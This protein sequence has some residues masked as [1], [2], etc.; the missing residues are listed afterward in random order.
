MTWTRFFKG[1]IQIKNG[2]QTQSCPGWWLYPLPEDLCWIY[3]FQGHLHQ[4]L[5]PGL[6]SENLER[7]HSLCRPS[8]GFS[9]LVESYLLAARSCI[10]AE[11]WVLP[12]SCLF[13]SPPCFS[14]GGCLLFSPPD[15]VRSWLN[16]PLSSHGFPRPF[17]GRGRSRHSLSPLNMIY[18][19]KMW[20]QWAII[21]YRGFSI[22][23]VL[24][25]L[26]NGDTLS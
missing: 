13:F 6:D 9:P 24:K 15:A 25:T 19:H 5:S 17:L 11:V 8:L 16:I 20:L 18:T 21:C 1:F 14:E 4:S 23:S 26:R 2:R 3:H 22:K 12:E 7:W 10:F